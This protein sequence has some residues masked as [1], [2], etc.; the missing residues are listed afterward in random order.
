MEGHTVDQG[1]LSYLFPAERNPP[2]GGTRRWMEI[3]N[4]RSVCRLC[5]LH[6]GILC[7][8]WQGLLSYAYAALLLKPRHP[9]DG[10][11]DRERGMMV[12]NKCQLATTWREFHLGNCLNQVG[13]WGWLWGS[14]LIVN[15]GWKTCPEHASTFPGF[16]FWIVR[17]IFF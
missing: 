13:L 12:S 6:L 3:N 7:C 8:P 5:L 16:S 1:W 17:C 10:L 9:E 15:W 4:T 2:R 14:I 11:G